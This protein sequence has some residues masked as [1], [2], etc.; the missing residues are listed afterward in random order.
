MLATSLL[1]PPVASYHWLAGNLAAQR[2]AG[3][4]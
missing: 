3:R 1:I 4:R 2:L